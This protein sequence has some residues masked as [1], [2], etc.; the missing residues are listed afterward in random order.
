MERFSIYILSQTAACKL[1]AA[2][3]LLAA[4]KLQ[5]ACKLMVACK[6]LTACKLVVVCKLLV[7]CKRVAAC[8]FLTA[9]S[10]TPIRS[11]QDFPDYSQ[12]RLTNYFPW[13]SWNQFPPNLSRNI[14]GENKLQLHK[15]LVSTRLRFLWKE[16]VT[17]FTQYPICPDF[18]RRVSI[19][20]FCP[21]GAESSCNT[22]FAS[23][24]E[25]TLENISLFSN[26]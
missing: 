18:S 17:N 13:L 1:Q 5:A 22:L 4:C 23:L 9:G 19:R 11:Q 8:K 2:C 16:S 25:S 15:S 14:R 20:L 3:K 7:A 21:Q 26:K 10:S 6:L 24:G 12:Q